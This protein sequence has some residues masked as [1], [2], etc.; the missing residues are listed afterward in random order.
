MKLIVGVLS[1]AKNLTITK[2]KLQIYS[3]HF[4]S[5]LAYLNNVWD[6]ELKSYLQALERIYIEHGSEYCLGTT[7]LNTNSL[8]RNSNIMHLEIRH[9]YEQSCLL[10][11]I[12]NNLVVKSN[13]C[14]CYKQ[15]LQQ[16]EYEN[17]NKHTDKTT[18]RQ[19]S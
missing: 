15:R 14:R 6:G 19:T 16:L 17:I 2:I 5:H 12:T 10:H 18:L 13:I 4:N 1:P 7:I 9:F 3:S 8:Q 11:K